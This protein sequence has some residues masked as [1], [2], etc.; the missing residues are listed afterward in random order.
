MKLAES[1][2]TRQLWRQLKNLQS[3]TCTS[4]MSVSTLIAANQFPCDA[5][6]WTREKGSS[7]SISGTRDSETPQHRCD[8]RCDTSQEG[9]SLR[10]SLAQSGLQGLRSENRR[11]LGCCD[12]SRMHFHAAVRRQLCGKTLLE[13]VR[14][15]TGLA[16][17]TQAMQVT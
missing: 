17:L 15:R 8:F 10:I 4:S 9:V 2:W 16:T 7:Q 3:G 11:V 1:H 5:L 12:R 6:T 14:S 13:D